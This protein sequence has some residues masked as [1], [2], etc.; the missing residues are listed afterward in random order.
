MR[1][2]VRGCER[3]GTQ[4]DIPIRPA[5]FQVHFVS[6]QQEDIG[7]QQARQAVSSTRFR[8]TAYA[9]RVVFFLLTDAVSA[10]GRK[11]KDVA[12]LGGRI[13]KG[14][15]QSEI[16]FHLARVMIPV[17]NIFA[18]FVLCDRVP[19]QILAGIP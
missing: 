12:T 17:R 15:T 3:L 18:S 9:T 13:T 4:Q 6:A 14:F 1:R 8:V 19:A 5:Q 10:E 2:A 7:A 11:P 16:P